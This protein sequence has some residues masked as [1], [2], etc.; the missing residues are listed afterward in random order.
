[1]GAAVRALRITTAPCACATNEIKCG[2]DFAYH[3]PQPRGAACVAA[4][5]GL[6]CLRLSC[7][8]SRQVPCEHR[9]TE[10]PYDRVDKP[11]ICGAVEEAVSNNINMYVCMGESERARERTEE[12]GYSSVSEKNGVQNAQ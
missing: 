2:L 11:T 5:E 8:H 12:R 7:P 4:V 9:D 6:V 3:G 10:L 1:M